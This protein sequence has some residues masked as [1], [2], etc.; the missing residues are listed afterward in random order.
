[1]LRE[2]LSEALE[3]MKNVEGKANWWKNIKNMFPGSSLS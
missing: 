2:L 3:V 1:M